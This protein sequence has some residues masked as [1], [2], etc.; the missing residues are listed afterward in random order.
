MCGLIQ[1]LVS[2]LTEVKK[3]E[4]AKVVLGIAHEVAPDPRRPLDSIHDEKT[5][6]LATYQLCSYRVIAQ[7]IPF[8]S[9]STLATYQFEVSMWHG[10]TCTQCVGI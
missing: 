5:G 3:A 2:N 1:G 6:S 10:P 9:M 4:L 8:G 7:Y